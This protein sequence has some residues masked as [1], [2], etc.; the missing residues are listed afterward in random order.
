MPTGLIRALRCALLRLFSDLRTADA[1]TF[2]TKDVGAR[3]LKSIQDFDN[4]IS[5][6][7]VTGWAQL[8]HLLG[9][10]TSFFWRVVTGVHG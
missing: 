2:N 3:L 8:S 5:E 6:I 1:V 4:P 7:E 9:H 10:E